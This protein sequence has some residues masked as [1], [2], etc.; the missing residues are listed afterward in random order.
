MLILLLP[1]QADLENLNT[2]V[3]Y[4]MVGDDIDALM[5]EMDKSI[6]LV[7]EW[8]VS[9][10]IGLD[11]IKFALRTIVNFMPGIYAWTWGTSWLAVLLVGNG[12]IRDNYRMIYGAYCLGVF[13]CATCLFPI[14]GLGA[15]AVIP[16][17]DFCNGIPVTGADTSNFLKTF[18]TT[19]DIMQVNRSILSILTDC[20]TKPDG[21]LWN[22]VDLDR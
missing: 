9:I 10:N 18:T 14:V 15:M 3:P 20:F 1:R 6:Q 21:V 17:S 2:P 22:V 7:D 16:M 11:G 8:M 5:K 19:G 4:E 13:A 12:M